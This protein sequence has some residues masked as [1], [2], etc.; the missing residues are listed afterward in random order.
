VR[1][2]LDTH[3]LLWWAAGDAKLSK[4]VGEAVIGAANEVLVSAASAWEIAT[5]VR[6]GKL[7]W[8]SEAGSVSD[9]VLSQGF[10][11]LSITVQHAERAGAL[12]I[13]HGDPFD[14]M[15]IAQAACEG[16]LLASNEALFDTFGVHRFW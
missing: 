4:R 15:L 10:L 12:A 9:Y 16:L 11:P 13:A 6:L 14:R 3:A 5:K 7:R 2:L 1:L 8:P